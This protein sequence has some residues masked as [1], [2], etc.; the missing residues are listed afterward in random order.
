MKIIKGKKMD[1]IDSQK[2]MDYFD[3]CIKFWRNKKKRAKKDSKEELMAACY[4]DAF[5]SAKESIFAEDP[6]KH[7]VWQCR[8]GGPVVVPDGGDAPLRQAVEETF[9]KMFGEEAVACFS[10]WGEKWTELEISVIRNEGK[11]NR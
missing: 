1:I 6:E 2:A 7:K 8:I 5:R 9:M 4:I 3:N 10:G 11:R